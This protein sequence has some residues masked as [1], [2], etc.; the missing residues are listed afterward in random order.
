MGGPYISLNV[1]RFVMF[2]S[3]DIIEK[4]NILNHIAANPLIECSLS[5]VSLS[6]VRIIKRDMVIYTYLNPVFIP[7][8]HFYAPYTFQCFSE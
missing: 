8:T 1:G 6:C 4:K 2:D 5:C 3:N 7:H